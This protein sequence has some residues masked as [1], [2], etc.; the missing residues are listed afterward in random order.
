MTNCKPIKTNEQLSQ[1]DQIKLY[2]NPAMD[3]TSLEFAVSKAVD[4]SNTERKPAIGRQASGYYIGK[5]RD[6]KGGGMGAHVQ[7][8]GEE[9][10]RTVDQT[11]R[12]LDD[13]HDRR[14]DDDQ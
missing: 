12:Y 1:V 3:K 2:P 7:A 5:H 10:H 11:G 14:D 6:P 9:R 13:H 4:L 8:V